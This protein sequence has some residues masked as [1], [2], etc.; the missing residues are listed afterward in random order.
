MSDDLEQFVSEAISPA[1]GSADP[2][3]MARGEPGFPSRFNWRGTTYQL[4]RVLQSWKSST[5]DRGELYLR[6]HWFRV[7]TTSGAQMTVYCERQ[8]RSRQHPKSRWWIYSY[9]PKPPA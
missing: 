6:R 7:L 8:A 3:A 2:S 4:D 9:K 1:P 5:R